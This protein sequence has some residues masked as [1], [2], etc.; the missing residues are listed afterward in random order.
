MLAN[1]GGAAADGNAECA[2]R[3]AG[4]RC[5]RRA[6]ARAAIAAKRRAQMN[7]RWQANGAAAAN[8]AGV[9]GV[10]LALTLTNGGKSAANAANQIGAARQLA[11]KC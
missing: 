3:N 8:A 5:K 10:A 7:W 1:G 9:G 11:C 6:P 4:V 2:N